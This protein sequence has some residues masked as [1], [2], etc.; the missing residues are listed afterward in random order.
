[1][2]STARLIPLRSRDRMCYA[3]QSGNFNDP[4]PSGFGERNSLPH[5]F[6]LGLPF[7]FARKQNLINPWRRWQRLELRFEFRNH[8][9]E[10]GEWLKRLNIDREEDGALIPAIA[11]HERKPYPAQAT[12]D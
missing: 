6:P 12:T 1:M 7:H 8:L 11:R 10:R 4:L 2:K 5:A 3:E 9:L